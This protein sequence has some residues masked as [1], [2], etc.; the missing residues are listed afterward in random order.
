MTVF[1]IY[2]VMQNAL[3]ILWWWFFDWWFFDWWLF[4]RW[5]FNRWLGLVFVW[6]WF[7]WLFLGHMASKHRRLSSDVFF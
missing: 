4:G 2:P 7:G 6:W 5:I 1:A 3:T